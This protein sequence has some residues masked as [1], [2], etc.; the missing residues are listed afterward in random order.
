MS[1]R[2]HCGIPE[3]VI[4]N[5]EQLNLLR[6]VTR[7]PGLTRGFWLW[8]PYGTLRFFLVG[9]DELIELE[10]QCQLHQ[11]LVFGSDRG[12][13]D[14]PGRCARKDQSIHIFKLPAGVPTN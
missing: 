5:I 3:I 12:K 8:S 10:C 7:S 1:R 14:Q 11:P 13:N 4:Q 2:V 6:S 9:D